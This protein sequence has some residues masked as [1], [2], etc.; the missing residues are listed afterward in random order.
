[1]TFTEIQSEVAERLNLTSATALA[2]IGRSINQRYRRLSSSIGLQTTA[3]GIVTASTVI[4]NR[5][6]TFGPTPSPVEKLYA[7]YDASVSPPRV[8]SEASFDELRNAVVGTDP[9]H[10]YAIQ[11]VGASSVT[12]TLN[13]V[14]ASI[15]VLTADA[16]LNLA[17]LSGSQVPAF[18]E[19]FHDVLVHGAMATELEKMEKIDLAKLQEGHY[20]MRLAELRFDIAKSAYREFYQGKT[21]PTGRR[22]AMI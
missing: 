18:T 5:S 14:P 19:S 17:T 4:G 8:L 3:R 12:I 1:M 9:A 22:T 11:V 20:E 21:A 2:R 15:Y 10:T 16:R 13:T 7:V 6:L